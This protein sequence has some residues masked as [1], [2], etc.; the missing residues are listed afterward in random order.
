VDSRVESSDG[1]AS[2]V[3]T[4][5]SFSDYWFSKFDDPSRWFY[6]GFHHDAEVAQ[7][8]GL[9]QAVVNQE[10]VPETIPE[11]LLVIVIMDQ[12]P[13]HFYRS[14]GQAYELDGRALRLAKQLHDKGWHTQ[15][16][17][18]ELIF[19][20]TVFE[21]SEDI[22]EHRFARD[23]L[24]ERIDDHEAHTED[25]RHLEKALLY[26]D[27]HSNVIRVFGRYPK[28]AEVQGSPLTDAEQQYLKDRA[29]KPY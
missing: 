2:G 1:D 16:S 6:E 23:L 27:K 12:L 25:H 22:S 5:K 19:W 4:L 3:V 10:I 14:N 13:R 8:H 17:T 26:L 24:L 28:R 29:G 7:F 9:L 11:H 20:I 18:W 21:H 15:L